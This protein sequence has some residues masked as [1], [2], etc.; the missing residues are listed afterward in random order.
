MRLVTPTPSKSQ[1]ALQAR[2]KSGGEV[3]TPE[4]VFRT[5][6]CLDLSEPSQDA[7]PPGKLRARSRGPAQD[8]GSSYTLI[9]TTRLQ[10]QPSSAAAGFALA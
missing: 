8:L 5:S 2:H 9:H 1:L 7:F 10:Q 3:W 4:R 6:K